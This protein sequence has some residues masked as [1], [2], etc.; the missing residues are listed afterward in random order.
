M[1]ALTLWRPWP[2]A[3]FHLDADIAKRVENR[4]WLPPER[5]LGERI[6][7]HA[8]KRWDDF[9]ADYIDEALFKVG[10]MKAH[11][12]IPDRWSRIEAEGIIGTAMVCG[13]IS[14]GRGLVSGR[15]P[16]PVRKGSEFDANI[17]NW[18][19]G[20][21]GW[22]LDEVVTLSEPIPCKGRQGLWDVPP[23][24]AARLA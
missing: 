18:F 14:G 13:V 4:S 7:I 19:I 9:G 3:I 23:E 17:Y 16:A 22:L 24:I 6:A 5:I 15:Y 21:F 2:Y 11:G 10:R 8:G 1:K 20:P 12:E